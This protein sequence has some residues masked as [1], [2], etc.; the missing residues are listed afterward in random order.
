[1]LNNGSRRQPK[2]AQANARRFGPEANERAVHDALLRLERHHEL[3]QLLLRSHSYGHAIW[4]ELQHASSQREPDHARSER[5]RQILPRQEY[6]HLFDS[7]V[8]F[9]PEAAFR[10]LLANRDVA[11]GVYPIKRFNWPDEG[12][13][14]GM[15]R[16]QFETAYTDYPFNPIMKNDKPLS[17]LVDADGFLEV[18]EAPT[19][20]MVIKRRVIY[21]MTRLSGAAIRSG[22]A[23]RQSV[24]Q[25]LLAFL[26][27]HGRSGFRPL[28]FRGLCILPALP[29]HR[30]QGLRRYSL[31]TGALGSA[32]VSWRSR[33]EP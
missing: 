7:D 17:D 18:A 19:G 16:E 1:M 15:T 2:E 20:F 24:G 6:T 12:L 26:R 22:W 33:Q 21:D 32:S 13:P 29:G 23:G 30:R 31:A 9:R 4:P 11:A 3:C 27:L 8:S 10:L 25:V 28:P 14:E 5:D